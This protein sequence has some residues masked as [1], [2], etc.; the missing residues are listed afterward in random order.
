MNRQMIRCDPLNDQPQSNSSFIG[1]AQSSLFK[2]PVRT[3][4]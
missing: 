1:E 2:D 4:L 3:A